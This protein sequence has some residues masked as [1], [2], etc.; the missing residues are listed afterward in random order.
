MNAESRFPLLSLGL[1]TA[2]VMASLAVAPTVANGQELPLQLTWVDRTGKE[3]QPVGVPGA[4]RGPDVAGDGRVAVHRHDR[5]GGDIWLFDSKGQMTRFTTDATGTQENSSP[6][7]SP[8]G[9]RIV[10]ASLRNGKWG[11][12][13]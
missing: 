11:L 1:A 8:D 6:V 13:L 9:T 7:F 5:L 12:Y 2:F 3:I 4:Y 10:F